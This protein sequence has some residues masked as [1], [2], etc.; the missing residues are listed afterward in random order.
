MEPKNNERKIR[1][2]EAGT[3]IGIAGLLFGI[4][5]FG[6]TLYMSERVKTLDREYD[7]AM[8]YRV[9]IGYMKYNHAA[10]ST[11][12]TDARHTGKCK[13]LPASSGMIPVVFNS[14]DEQPDAQG[15]LGG[16]PSYVKI[17]DRTEQDSGGACNEEY[18]FM[19]IANRGSDVIGAVHLRFSGEKDEVIITNLKAGAIDLVPLEVSGRHTDLTRTKLRTPLEAWFMYESATR[20]PR[21][22][23]IAIPERASLQTTDVEGRYQALP[24]F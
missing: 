7:E 17:W 16:W 8:R 1:K 9:G 3:W 10:L 4:V 23:R 15:R 11:L 2:W 5:Q 22:Y 20:K 6:I 21:T 12:L 13:S 18:W 14:D 24:V 19:T